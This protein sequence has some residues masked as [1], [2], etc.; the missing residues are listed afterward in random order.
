MHIYSVNINKV[1]E[2]D[3]GYGYAKTFSAIL[4]C[5]VEMVGEHRVCFR[6]V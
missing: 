1:D 4:I 6:N 2:M 5:A 3:G